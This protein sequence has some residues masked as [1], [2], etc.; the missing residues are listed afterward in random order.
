VGGATVAGSATV[1]AVPSLAI[2]GTSAPLASASVAVSAR[3]D[4]AAGAVLSSVAT[5][6]AAAGYLDVSAGVADLAGAC[7]VLAV[8]GLAIPGSAG[9]LGVGSPS[10]HLGHSARSPT[11]FRSAVNVAGADADRARV[12]VARR[13]PARSVATVAGASADASTVAGA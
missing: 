13:R 1:A 12:H 9:L 8:P 5:V 11:Y 6:S 3:L 4:Y 2:P 10:A 7:L